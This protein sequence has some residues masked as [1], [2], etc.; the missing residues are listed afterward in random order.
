VTLERI[1]VA[2]PVVAYTKDATE[3]MQYAPKNDP[4]HYGVTP[5]KTNGVLRKN[6]PNYRL[7]DM[8]IRPNGGLTLLPR[9]IGFLAA[10]ESDSWDWEINGV[11]YT[12]QWR[13]RD[14]TYCDDD[15]GVDLVVREVMSWVRADLRFLQQKAKDVPWG[16][17]YDWEWTTLSNIKICVWL[18]ED[19]YETLS[20]NRILRRGKKMWVHIYFNGPIQEVIRF[21]EDFRPENRPVQISLDKIQ[22]GGYFVD[23]PITGIQHAFVNVPPASKA[24]VAQTE[25]IVNLVGADLLRL[26]RAG[27]ENSGWERWSNIGVN[28]FRRW[29][30]VKNTH[31]LPNG[32]V[33]ET[34]TETSGFHISTAVY[35][36]SGDPASWDTKLFQDQKRAEGESPKRGGAEQAP[37][38]RE[39]L[40]KSSEKVGTKF[41]KCLARISIVRAPTTREEFATGEAIVPGQIVEG[42]Q[43][44]GPDAM[45][46]MLPNGR[47]FVPD[48]HPSKTPQFFQK[49]DRKEAL[50]GNQSS[51]PASP[52]GPGV[53]SPNAQQQRQQLELASAKLHQLQGTAAT[54]QPGSPRG[55]SSPNSV[56]TASQNQRFG[57][58]R[59]Y[60]GETR[61]VMTTGGAAVAA[62]AVRTERTQ[63]LAQRLAQNGATSPR[64]IAVS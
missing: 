54:S 28:V 26:F 39:A 1:D 13:T 4:K 33:E 62:N 36:N 64:Q 49:A 19:A 37:W 48:N 57:V 20:T 44:M 27:Q 51:R 34:G 53:G 3:D 63:A 56:R 21:W 5:N 42:L 41:W 52:R 60:S 31:V 45:Y 8:G 43:L 12:A 15:V 23:H 46:L 59:S 14:W 25:E 32:Q 7:I 38:L 35:A 2:K 22:R 61:Q 16:A 11:F 6:I 24:R 30:R 18:E 10:L 55:G 40:N 58:E 47:G 9:W 50:L 29:E 17:G